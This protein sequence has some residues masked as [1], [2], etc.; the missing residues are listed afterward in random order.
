MFFSP[1]PL[2]D[3]ERLV[4]YYF[5]NH[6]FFTKENGI[7]LKE[8][9]LRSA[10]PAIKSSENVSNKE[11][12]AYFLEHSIKFLYPTAF[13]LFN[14]A[15]WLYYLSFYWKYIYL[16]KSNA[17]SSFFRRLWP[18]RKE[19]SLLYAHKE[20]VKVPKEGSNHFTQ[21]GKIAAY[22]CVLAKVGKTFCWKRAI[23]DAAFVFQI[24]WP[25]LISHL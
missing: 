2:K 15:Y 5:Q 18:G 23:R 22:I 13:L 24:H 12:L 10:L 1:I 9:Q 6:C 11:E 14:I 4:T 25:L 7:F 20:V 19:Q 16:R 8:S 21:V 17:P 3:S